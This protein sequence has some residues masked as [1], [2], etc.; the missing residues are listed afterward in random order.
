MSDSDNYEDC[1]VLDFKKVA[2]EVSGPFG[3]VGA[4]LAGNYSISPPEDFHRKV[5]LTK[6]FD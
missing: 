6:I 4:L 2:Y 1:V 5:F 3:K